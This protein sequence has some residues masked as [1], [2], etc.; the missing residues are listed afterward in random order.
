MP[1]INPQTVTG[2]AITF[3]TNKKQT[4][5]KMKN[6]LLTIAAS[7]GMTALTMAQNVPNYVPTN[8]L[9][10]WWPFNGNANDESGN[11]NN[12]TVNGAALTTD[13]YNNLNNA[14]SFN[15]TTDYIK[16]AN[17]ILPN[18]PSSCSFSFWFNS[19]DNDACFLSDRAAGINYAKYQ[20]MISSNKVS[21]NSYS[22]GCNSNP[23]QSNYDYNVWN[24]VVVVKDNT[25]SSEYLYLNGVLIATVNTLCY[26]SSL[27]ST[28]IGRRGGSSNDAY[29]SGKIDDIGIWNRALTQQEITNLYNGCQLTVNTQPTNQTININTKTQFVVSSSN[30]IATYQWQTDLGFGFQNLSN[31]GQ[32]SG[33]TNDTLTVSNLTMSNNNQ[34]FRCIV[35]SG[36]CTDTSN[37]AS[38]SFLTGINELFS[39]NLFSVFPNPATKQI[40]V[41]ADATLLGSNYSI[42]DNTGKSVLKGK[43]NSANTVIELG[44]LSGGVY[45]FSVG[46][47]L[48]QTFKVIKE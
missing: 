32:Y 9:V 4:N 33:T 43:I 40:D 47:N 18:T 39:S 31:A 16:V 29:Y 21:S 23:V 12:G 11:G 38:L 41:K 7:F 27:N 6:L 3:A 45:L 24:H 28:N 48:K 22:S 34:Q 1:D 42:Y 35:T 19:S 44:S 26:W 37:V 15:G 2:K 30:P 13:R 17:S 14:Y 10:G 46:E 36:S 8:G 20:I 25:Q 5:M